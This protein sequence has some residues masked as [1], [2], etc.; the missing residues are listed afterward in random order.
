MT[1][2]KTKKRRW[3]RILKRVLLVF[4][5]VFVIFY[6]LV[7][8]LL[9]PIVEAQIKQQL[10]EGTNGFYTLEYDS[11][12][13]RLGTSGLSISF[14]NLVLSCDTTQYEEL[15]K[16]PVLFVKSRK[17]SA[18]ILNLSSV[19]QGGEL[20]LKDMLLEQPDIDLFR[21]PDYLI[22]SD[23]L[24]GKFG[25]SSIFRFETL[26]VR[27]GSL[28]VIRY[29]DLT[30]TILSTNNSNIVMTNVYA[31]LNRV[32]L[33][34]RSVRA[35]DIRCIT[36]NVQFRPANSRYRFH[37]DSMRLNWANRSATGHKLRVWPVS[38]VGHRKSD[39]VET[40]SRFTLEAQQFNLNDFNFGSFIAD[41][42]ASVGS[43][44]LQSPQAV[45][46]IDHNIP[47]DKSHEK[48]TLQ[49]IIIGLPIPLHVDT[50]Q[51]HKGHLDLD[52]LNPGF[53]EP[54]KVTLADMSVKFLNLDNRAEFDKTT[55]MS[56]KGVLNKSGKV[57]FNLSMPI[58]DPNGYHQ[59]DGSLTDMPF[60]DW[61]QTLSHMVRVRVTSGEISSL[62]FA[63]ECT[64]L[65][66][67]GR[68]LMLYEDF[69]LIVL[70]KKQE[71]EA[72]FL[73]RLA[74]ASIT[75]YNPRRVTNYT[76]EENFKMERDPWR[77]QTHLWVGGILK[78]VEETL[79][80]LP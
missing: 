39:S 12:S 18:H 16:F 70:D 73:S 1:E 79:T 47:P 24:L 62:T 44:V 72:L 8:M 15:R 60:P 13:A 25:E 21:K 27:D 36:A 26:A 63:A 38:I 33:P 61:N 49:Q 10:N 65:S 20:V 43:L 3:K 4:G 75:S 80:R 46:F 55:E 41:S 19:M 74:T 37:L 32:D 54:S 6:L 35:S 64:N 7:V 9:N 69:D 42:V 48:P 52:F 50:L 76:A 34:L 77:S 58:N 22:P 23:T 31:D 11:F 56:L 59:Y 40:T 66:S 51:V 14:T 78:G 17:L 67:Q 45:V 53:D 28:R 5:I 68:L 57:Q 2:P 71:H 29:D 30:D